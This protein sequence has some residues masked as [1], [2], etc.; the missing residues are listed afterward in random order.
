MNFPNREHILDTIRVLEMLS[1]VKKQD[2]VL[3]TIN[4]LKNEIPNPVS[5]AEYHNHINKR[6]S[7]EFRENKL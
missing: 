3:E 4:I 6:V 7:E 1:L 2:C 5:D